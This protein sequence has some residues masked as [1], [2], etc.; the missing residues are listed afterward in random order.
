MAAARANWKGYLRLSLCPPDSPV[1]RH[2]RK[3]EAF[4]PPLLAAPSGL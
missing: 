2:D 3:R 4:S 1:S